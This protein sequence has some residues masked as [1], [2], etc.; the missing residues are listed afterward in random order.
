MTARQAQDLYDVTIEGTYYGSA[1][2]QKAI[3][4]YKITVTMNEAAKK[5]GF[6]SAAR[7]FI[8]PNALR[9]QH[10]DYKRFRTHFV[11]DVVNRTS[12]NKPIQELALMNRPQIVKYIKQ[13]SLPIETDLYPE[14]SDLRQAVKSYHESK[15]AFLEYQK[16]RMEGK[17]VA[18]TL[19]RQ[20]QELNPTL[21][22][23]Q[24]PGSASTFDDPNFSAKPTTTTP[25]PTQTKSALDQ[26][27]DEDE[28]TTLPGGGEII[29]DE[30]SYFDENQIQIPE[31]DE[32]DEI[33]TLLLGL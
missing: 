16:K 1:N 5:F 31:L 20:L 24:I 15:D 30:E 17:G 26:F 14:I 2:G 23:P 22:V 29:V 3:H 19:H 28:D 10:K 8:L 4:P 7:S 32:K 12:P 18:L 27:Y 11:T 6:L 13:K 9:A 21:N 33:D 25:A